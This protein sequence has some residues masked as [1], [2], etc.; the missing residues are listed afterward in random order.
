MENQAG[1]GF[2]IGFGCLAMLTLGMLIIVLSMSYRKK[3]LE[4]ENKIQALYREKQIEILRA[5]I[6]AEERQKGS[7][8]ENLHDEIIPLLTVIGRNLDQQVRNFHA[9][10]FNPEQL[11][12]EVD[13]IEGVVEDIR[14]IAYDLI[15]KTVLSFG[16]IS[17][18]R[19][20]VDKLNDDEQIN[21]RFVNNTSFVEELPFSKE[22]Q[23]SIYRA[24]LEI[25]NNLYKHAQYADLT[26]SC[27][28]VQNGLQFEFAHDGKGITNDEIE[29]FRKSKIGLGL[30]SLQARLL[31]LNGVIDYRK[32]GAQGIV[33]IRIPIKS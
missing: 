31:I 28:H 10:R 6:A 19:Y 12:K 25:L 17:A 13:S 16:L 8:A 26:V 20:H 32:E 18:I 15:P 3:I 30:K 23:V 2:F 4:K 22:D 29:L 21:A 9:N 5:S 14:I 33:T 27:D 1:I 24:C 7:L 11:K